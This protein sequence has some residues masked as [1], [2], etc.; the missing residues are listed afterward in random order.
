[1]D[2]TLLKSIAHGS[3]DIYPGGEFT[4]FLIRNFLKETEQ[5]QARDGD[6]VL[7]FREG[8]PKHAG[9][10]YTEKVRSKWGYYSHLWQHGLYELPLEYGNDLRFFQ[11]LP[12]TEIE[13]AFK[14]WAGAKFMI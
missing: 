8:T 14:Q 6:L 13:Y 12:R 9:K 1:M 4:T 7:Y 11:Q 3:Q 2:H 5:D 10:W